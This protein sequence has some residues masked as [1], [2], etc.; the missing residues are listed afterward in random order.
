MVSKIQYEDKESIQNDEEILEKNKVTD[1][2]MNEIKQ[3]VN[4]NADET[5]NNTTSIEQLQEENTLLEQNMLHDTKVGEIITV[6]DSA[7]WKKNKLSVFGY[8]EQATRSGKNFHRISDLTTTFNGLTI[9]QDSA[10][11]KITLNG[12]TTGAWGHALFTFSDTD[13]EI[14][15]SSSKKYSVSLKT[16]GTISGGLYTVFG[17]YQD[18]TS[19]FDA[20][21]VY[22]PR[23]F[24]GAD[25]VVKSY[26]L[27]FQSGV[28]FK[29]YTIEIQIEEG[30]TATD[31]EPY[32]AMPSPE[33]KSD[34]QSVSGNLEFVKT[35]HNLLKS[36]WAQDL[37]DRL[38]ISSTSTVHGLSLIHI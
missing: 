32:G 19:I 24:T 8:S 27:Y 28:T 21:Y 36:T 13:T 1:S 10:T 25:K 23:T 18:S 2:N 34:V 4:E 33:F 31:Y 20:S 30:E 29:N 6:Q 3:V 16:S 14:T 26:N 22:F 37:L 9:V 7:K 12:T 17:R 38:N 15:F 5:Q 35:K 11:G